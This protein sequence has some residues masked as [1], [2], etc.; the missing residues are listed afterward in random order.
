ML[1]LFCTSTDL[2]NTVTIQASSDL[3]LA[4]ERFTLTCTVVC[5]RP[6]QMKWLNPTGQNPT[7]QGMHLSPQTF[8]GQVY[9]LQIHFDPIHTSHTGI[10]TCISTVDVPPSTQNATRLVRV[11]RELTKQSY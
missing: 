4:G 2:E 8:G 6:P 11:Q 1:Y 5:D 10:Y 9:S 7:G 3:P